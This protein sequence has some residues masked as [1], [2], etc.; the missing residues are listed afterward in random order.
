MELNV[1]A[2]VT[3]SVERGKL[4]VKPAMSKRKRYSLSELMKGSA[5]MKKLTVEAAW[6][7]DGEPIGRVIG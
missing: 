1:G 4:V 2:Q 3:L 5:G 6:A 7:H